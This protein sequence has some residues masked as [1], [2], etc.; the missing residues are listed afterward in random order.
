M[1]NKKPEHNRFDEIKHSLSTETASTLVKLKEATHIQTILED[2]WLKRAFAATIDYFILFFAA[3]IIWSTAHLAE[4]L[5]IMG[6]LSLV[7]F[8]VAE[9]FF[10]YTLGKKV[11][12]L[13]VVNLKGT[14]PSLKDSFTRNISKINAVFLI[15]D[16][17]IGRVTSSTH[18]KFFDRIA[19]T[20]VDDMSTIS[21]LALN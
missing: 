20:T 21:K 17:I 9:S 15:L 13:K 1:K 8:A 19:N 7:Y 16:T 11:F 3:G 12:S 4:F 2:F 10:G 14:K 5:L 18:Q 6:L